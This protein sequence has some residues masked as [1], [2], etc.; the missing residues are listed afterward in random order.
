[1]IEAQRNSQIRTLIDEQINLPSPPEI[2][3]NI[4]NTV[5]KDDSSIQ[6][7][8]RII[9]ADPAL[10]G[11]ILSV[12]NSSFYALPNKV[13]SVERA[14]SI[15]GSNLFKNIALSFLIA[16]ELRSDKQSTFNLDYFWRRSVT[17]AVAAE[18]LAKSLQEKGDDFFVAGLLHD[19]GVLVLY[20]N[21]GNEYAA[22]LHDRK[23]SA[24]P[25]EECEL[26][27]YGFTHQQLGAML[28]DTWGLPETISVPVHFH[29]LNADPPEEHRRMTEIISFAA[30]LAA[31]YNQTETAGKVR[32]LQ[33]EICDLY[34]LK[35]DQV[36]D[37]LDDVARESIDILKAFD[38]DPGDLKPYSQM[39]QEANEELGR[40]NLSY[41]HLAMELKEAKEKAENLASELTDVNSRLRELVFR[42]GLTGLYNHRYFQEI[43]VK[44]LSRAFRYQSSVSLIMFDIDFFKKVNDN[45]GHPV[46]DLVLMNIAR[47][48]EGAVRPSDIVARYGGEEFAVILP[49][50]D[51]PGMHVFAERLRRTVE[52]ITTIVGNQQISVTISAGGSSYS[53]SATKGTPQRLIAAA[54]QGLYASKRNG[55]NR[56]T[57]F[58]LPTDQSDPSS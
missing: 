41:E 18:L 24:E 26:R 55:R 38:L 16:A 50:T 30:R 3:V 7:L 27:Q 58:K 48:I 23:I 56:V 47:A 8:A 21:K 33:T 11:K 57:I 53:P 5:Q 19:I 37:L 40:L 9:K 52:G 28:I 31:I 2:A 49:Q 25:L 32:A 46:G 15:L 4:L 22:L 17:S 14:L 39:L 35:A 34:H 29:H 13:T 1:M 51:E 36:R 45:Y 42:D 54:D 43:L 6:E 44:E 10:T 20:L 12:A